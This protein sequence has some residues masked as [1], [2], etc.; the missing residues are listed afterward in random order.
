MSRQKG[1][2]GVL[3]YLDIKDALNM[4][5]DSQRGQLFSAILDYASEGI[6]PEFEDQMTGMAWAIIRPSID[7]DFE[8]YQAT[9]TKRTYASYCRVEKEAGREPLPFAEWSECSSDD[10]NDRQMVS[11]DT[12]WYQMHPTELNRTELNR[13]ELK[14]TEQN[15]WSNEFDELWALYP[16]KDGKKDAIRHYQRARKNGTT[17]EQ[18]K[19]GILNYCEYLKREKVE[20]RFIMMGSTWFNG[21]HWNDEYKSNREPTLKDY[22]KTADFSAWGVK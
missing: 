12:K 22:A 16:R 9:V 2:P 1:K 21:E 8:N 18:V 4:L 5:S 14:R 6:V 15:Q 7:R 3:I 19:A 20:Q 13:T 17:F 10:T 11:H